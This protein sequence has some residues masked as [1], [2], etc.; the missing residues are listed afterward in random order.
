MRQLCLV[1]PLLAATPATA[2]TVFAAQTLRAQTILTAQDLFVKDVDIS[3]AASDPAQLIGKETR[4]ALY[5]GR[6]VRTGDVGPPALVDRN[7]LVPLYYRSS[8]LSIT[9]EGRAL[10]RAGAG[11]Y[12]RVMNLASRS[13]VT[14]LVM[15]DG[16]VMV[17]R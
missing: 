15:P 16:R 17:A 5:A 1:L 13:T 10:Q 11:E 2:D 6:P 12:I 8:G 7:Q 9:T 3:G 4:V 14:G